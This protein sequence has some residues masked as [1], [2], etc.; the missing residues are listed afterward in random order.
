MAR[1]L[2]YRPP[3]A[4]RGTPT[5]A[6]KPS[7]NHSESGNTIMKRC[8]I[9]HRTS[10]DTLRFCSRDGAFLLWGEQPCP[11]C[12]TLHPACFRFCPVDGAPLRADAS[13][14]NRL[15]SSQMRLESARSARRQRF[16]RRH[17]L[18]SFAV[19]IFIF[20]AS[21]VFGSYYA[22]RS[23]E[24]IA[25]PSAAATGVPANSKADSN[26]RDARR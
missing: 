17:A 25:S 3:N 14:E 6:P 9:C 15:P 18:L 8:P 16:S 5:R 23:V 21:V 22:G 4:G 24:Q 2:I 19:S 10:D 20:I 26:S 12:G 13:A 1:R 7:P 11:T